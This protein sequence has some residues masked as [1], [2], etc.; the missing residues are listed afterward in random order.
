[1]QAKKYAYKNGVGGRAVYCA[2][3]TVHRL[4]SARRGALIGRAIDTPWRGRDGSD[5][6][7]A[8]GRAVG[9]A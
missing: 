6:G 7:A 1:V 2:D 4:C 8:A 9:A 5:P 3:R